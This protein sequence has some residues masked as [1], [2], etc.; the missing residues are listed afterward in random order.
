MHKKKSVSLII[1]TMLSI[2]LITVTSVQAVFHHSL[3]DLWAQLTNQLEEELDRTRVGRELN[4]VIED[5]ENVAHIVEDIQGLVSLAGSVSPPLA[6]A[7]LAI[8]YGHDPDKLFNRFQ[9][10]VDSLENNYGGGSSLSQT[11]AAAALQSVLEEPP[12]PD[13]VYMGDGCIVDLRNCPQV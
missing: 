7:N 8:R 4:R 1:F 3:G 2:M 11:E 5:V 10:R 12:L 9:E 6:V 13:G